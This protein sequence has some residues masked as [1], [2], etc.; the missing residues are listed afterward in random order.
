MNREITD[1]MLMLRYK[2]GV[3]DAFDS[4]FSRHNG[5]VYRYFLRQRQTQ[6][7][8]EELAQDVWMRV[9]QAAEHYEV[10]A[11][12]NTWLYRIAH[13]RLIDHVRSLNAR[14]EDGYDE[15]PAAVELVAIPDFEWPEN[16]NERRQRV[17]QLL[18]AVSELPPDQAEVF[19][20]HQESELTLEEIGSVMGI[21]R[22]TVKSRL[23]YALSKLRAALSD[24][25]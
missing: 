11:K 13:N 17:E 24:L 1:E 18:R 16:I 6:P 22:E 20:L 12:F 5:G 21:G 25:R 14:P 3:V 2:E 23:R 7:H 10:A 9:I 8:A 4:L 15:T 19:L